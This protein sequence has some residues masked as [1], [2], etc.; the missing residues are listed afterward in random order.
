[1]FRPW[2]PIK[3]EIE[4]WLETKELNFTQKDN[5]S[6]G[7][8]LHQYMQRCMFSDLHEAYLFY[9]PELLQA[10]LLMLNYTHLNNWISP[11]E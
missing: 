10:W 11:I 1:M 5:R 9:F 4:V 7:Y 6:S 2:N 8:T 3:K